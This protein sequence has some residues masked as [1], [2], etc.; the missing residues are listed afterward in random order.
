M[1]KLM[2]WLGSAYV[3]RYPYTVVCG[4]KKI[5]TLKTHST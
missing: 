2:A 5:F 1:M 4:P 3:E